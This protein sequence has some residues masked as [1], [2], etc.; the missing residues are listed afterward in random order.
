MSQ[1]NGEIVI[2]L[3]LEQSWGLGSLFVLT[4]DDTDITSTDL[5][6]CVDDTT[7]TEIVEKGETRIW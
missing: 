1:T 2:G 4:F 3:Y 6:K 7:A 5:W